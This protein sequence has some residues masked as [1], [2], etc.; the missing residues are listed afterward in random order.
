MDGYELDVFKSGE[1][2]LREFKPNII[3]ELAP[4]LFEENNYSK[5]NY[6]TFLLN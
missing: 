5:K 6:L 4:Y 1:N 2:I 3:M